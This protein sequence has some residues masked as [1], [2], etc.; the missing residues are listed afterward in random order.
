MRSKDWGII[1][2]ISKEFSA[3]DSLEMFRRVCRIRHFE[4]QVKRA[5]DAKLI[6]I[7]IYL[8]VGQ[9]SIAAAL[10]LAYPGPAIFG[11]H[12]CHDFYIAYGGDLPALRDE[13]L[14]R[15]SGCAKGMGG[16]A[17]I[18]SP[19]IP[20]FGHSGL[21]G[22]QIP[23]AVGY[24]MGK[25]ERVLAV[26]GDASAEEDYIFGALGYAAHK[27]LPVLFVCV[28]N[29]LS[30][31]TKVAVRRN[32]KMADVASG[33]GMRAEEITDDP[34]LLM[35]HAR[36]LREQ[37]P[38]FLNIHTVRHLWHSGTGTDGPPEWDRF[39]LIQEELARMGLGEK[40]SKAEVIA[41][42]EMEALWAHEIVSV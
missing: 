35:H 7:P 14:H 39:A 27:N 33:F 38:A 22:D 31:L 34:W 37:L 36:R 21:M 20:M 28:D 4:L 6:K 16:S 17:S 25:G 26:M 9:E 29:G 8:S 40:A 10:S 1:E 42:E 2:N 41:R 13:L 19:A 11:Q 23:I 32:W 30:I 5:F 3:E 18:H 24:A 12:R 15:P